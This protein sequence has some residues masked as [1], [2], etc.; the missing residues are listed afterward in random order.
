MGITLGPITGKLL[1]Q[2]V[3]EGASPGELE[4]F[5]IERFTR[6]QA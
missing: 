3:L 4:P 1:A 6:K 2:V 5:S